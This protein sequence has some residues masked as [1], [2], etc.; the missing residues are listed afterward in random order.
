MSGDLSAFER[1]IRGSH[2]SKHQGVRNEI[3]DEKVLLRRSREFWLRIRRVGK[4][5]LVEANNNR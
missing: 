5:E 1:S 2:S 3:L 4:V